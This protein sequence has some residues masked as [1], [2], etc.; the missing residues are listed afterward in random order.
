MNTAA[1]RYDC[2]CI[3]LWGVGRLYFINLFQTLY[4]AV[5]ELLNEVIRAFELQVTAKFFRLID[6]LKA[7][8]YC[9]GAGHPSFSS[10]KYQDHSKPHVVL[11]PQ[12]FFKLRFD[13]HIQPN[14]FYLGLKFV[15]KTVK[16]LA[17]RFHLATFSLRTWSFTSCSIR[18]RNPL[19]NSYSLTSKLFSWGFSYREP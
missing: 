15:T 1:P 13:L 16:A 4:I 17:S 8:P 5:I 2:K 6:L 11:L 19:F 10:S 12:H 3:L 14:I 9:S 7:Q 18:H